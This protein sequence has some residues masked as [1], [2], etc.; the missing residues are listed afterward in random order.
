MFVASLNLDYFFKKVFSNERIAKKFLEDLLGVSISDLKLLAVEN[1][2]TDDSVSVK[3]DFRCKIHGNYVVIEMQQ[4]YKVDVVKRFFL[5][6]ALSTALQLETLKPVKVT[7]ANGET[8]TEKNYSSLEPVITLIW[9]VDDMLGFEDDFIVYTTLPETAK[10]FITNTDLWQQPLETILTEREKVIEIL[11]NKTKGLDFFSKN[12][13][14]YIFQKN[15][16]KNKKIESPYY[17]WFDFANISR[18]PDNTEQDFSNFKNDKAMAEVI[19]RLRK[20]KFTPDEFKYVSDL[21]SYEILLARKD[22]D[23]DE[24]MALQKQHERKAVEQERQKAE[25][26]RQKAIQAKQEKQLLQIEFIKVLLNQKIQIPKI[27]ETLKI[28]IEET[29]ALIEK[30][31]IEKS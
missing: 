25:Q 18:N 14:I 1:K 19:N 22:E 28:S 29:T 26:E 27:A 11:E 7:K 9:M 2:L 10:D 4:K 6:H 3:F 12:R 24:A 13:L 16:V 15:I 23:H 8:Y 31:Q 20:D 30:I 17:K 21:D 5:Y